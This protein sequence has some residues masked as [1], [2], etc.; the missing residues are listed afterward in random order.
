MKCWLNERSIPMR[1]SDTWSST[2]VSGGSSIVFKTNS[3]KSSLNWL[4]EKMETH[5]KK[6]RQ[7][8]LIILFKIN[9][10]P[11]VKVSV[12][13]RV[14]DLKDQIPITYKQ[15]IRLFEMSLTS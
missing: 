10:I 11:M 12:P 2:S 13:N 4:R 8:P 5:E 6:I 7:A 1:V 14:F 3:T 9:K 15:P